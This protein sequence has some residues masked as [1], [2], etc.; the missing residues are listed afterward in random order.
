[1]SGTKQALVTGAGGFAG[2]HLVDRLLR[3]GWCVRAFVRYTSAGLAGWL[4]RDPPAARAD[5]EVVAGDVRDEQAVRDA[6]VGVD[7]VFHLA[8]LV[9]IPYSY[10]HPREVVDTNVTGTLN[11]LT[12]A[13]DH[14]VRRVVHASTSEVYGSAVRVPMDEDHPLQA[15]SPYAA[16]KIGAEKLV[17]SFHASFGVPTVVMR[18][19]NMFG[20]RQSQ[21]A[22]IPVVVSQALSGRTIRLGNTSARRDFTFVG[23]TMD[24]FVRAAATPAAV[25]QVFN[26]GTGR[27]IAVGDLARLVASLAGRADIDIETDEIRFRPEQS[28]VNRLC[29]DSR[30]ALDVLGWTPR[31][32]LEDGLR[33]TLEW[34]GAHRGHENP[35]VYAV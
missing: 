7:T 26:V 5:V 35:A 1:V 2:S 9:G 29:A 24:A 23:D 8:A 12:A 15:Q 4:D 6:M 10:Q 18:A 27:D 13:R 34:F 21:R 31:L 19:F 11:V 30:R 16:S 20:P 28:E 3:D 14:G 17:E 32:S 22:V 33:A 25:G